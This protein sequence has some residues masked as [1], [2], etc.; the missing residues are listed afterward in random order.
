[1]KHRFL[2]DLT[3]E[4]FL[5]VVFTNSANNTFDGLSKKVSKEVCQCHTPQFMADKSILD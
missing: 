1:V 2:V 3:E 4:G 5:D